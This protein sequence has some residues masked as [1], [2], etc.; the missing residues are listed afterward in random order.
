M[1]VGRLLGPGRWATGESRRGTSCY[2]TFT[3]PAR[4]PVDPAQAEVDLH[5]R[6]ARR[7]GGGRPVLAAPAAHVP[8]V[9][10][11]TAEPREPRGKRRR[12]GS[13]PDA[14]PAA[15]AD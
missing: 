2:C 15:A 7:S 4:L 5:L 9:G 13:R 1:F 10:A 6:A 3:R 8:G 14:V 11:G 12:A